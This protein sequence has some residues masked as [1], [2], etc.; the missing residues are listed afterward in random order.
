MQ[1]KLSTLAGKLKVASEEDFC[2]PGDSK[3]V[4]A[5]ADGATSKATLTTARETIINHSVP[6]PRWSDQTR[7]DQT[8]PG[9]SR[10][11]ERVRC[12]S[13]LQSVASCKLI[14]TPL[15]PVAVGESC[16]ATVRIQTYPS[17]AATEFVCGR[18][19]LLGTCK[20]YLKFCTAQ[21]PL[22]QWCVNV[23]QWPKSVI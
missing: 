21:K 6:P 22:A 19:Q 14:A 12:S 16:P 2:Q 8:R 13:C 1:H 20:A 17:A 10:A 15:V 11:F 3:E 4:T 5:A 9:W 23:G 18:L 7:T